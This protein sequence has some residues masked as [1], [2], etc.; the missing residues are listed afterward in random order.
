[1]RFLCQLYS[2]LLN[3]SRSNLYLY[4][5]LYTF[6]QTNTHTGLHSVYHDHVASCLCHASEK[7]HYFVEKA[8]YKLVLMGAELL[9]L[10]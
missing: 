8:S 3:R 2:E 10:G 1:M 5:L 4:L 9:T 6:E 7:F